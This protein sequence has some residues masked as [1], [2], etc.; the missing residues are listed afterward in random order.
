MILYPR[1]NY[2]TLITDSVYFPWKESHIFIFNLENL[3]MTNHFLLDFGCN[4]CL[5]LFS[6]L[7]FWYDISKRYNLFIYIYYYIGYI[8]ELA[9]SQMFTSTWN[10]YALNLHCKK[11]NLRYISNNLRI[12][13]CQ[14]AFNV[15]YYF[16]FFFVCVLSITPDWPMI[17][18]FLALSDHDTF[19]PWC[20]F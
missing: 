7:I 11:I 12:L 2:V 15:L 17:N 10:L 4:F 13:K 1:G 20:D 14:I 6:S 18:E 9:E 19:M 16:L 8:I 5:V 3:K